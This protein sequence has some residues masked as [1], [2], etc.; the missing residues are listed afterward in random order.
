MKIT[1]KNLQ[2]QTFI[3]EIDSGKTVRWPRGVAPRCRTAH[4]AFSVSGEAPQAEDRGGEGQ[5]LRGGVPE[6]D[7]R[8]LV[9]LRDRG[10]PP[11][12]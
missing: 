9:G 6:T 7:L 8:W 3:V 1:L 5:G 2:Q 11:R 10:R 12:P 4:H